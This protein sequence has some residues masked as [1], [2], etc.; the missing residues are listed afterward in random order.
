MRFHTGVN[1]CWDVGVL[2]P[3][4]LAALEPAWEGFEGPCE[5]RF[6]EDLFA[7]PKTGL[8]AA[9]VDP[10]PPPPPQGTLDAASFVGEVPLLD[11]PENLGGLARRLGV[12]SRS[13]SAMV[14]VLELCPAAMLDVRDT[15]DGPL[16]PAWNDDEDWGKRFAGVVG[17][18]ATFP[19]R[20]DESKY[21]LPLPSVL[22]EDGLTDEGV[23][24]KLNPLPLFGVGSPETLPR[25][26]VALFA[27]PPGAEGKGRLFVGDEAAEG[28]RFGADCA[29]PA[30]F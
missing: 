27:A 20:V 29:C 3:A 25:S 1:F 30:R 4:V 19:L 2:D 26:M 5:L 9:V 8:V 18:S 6:V 12:L 15:P 13:L 22:L 10:P 17:S 21:P 14:V 11:V 23:P 24:L 28:G 16:F 7:P